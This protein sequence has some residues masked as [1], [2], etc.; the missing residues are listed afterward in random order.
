VQEESPGE[1]SLKNQ[2]KTKTVCWLE[3]IV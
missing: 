1:K 2:P 3:L